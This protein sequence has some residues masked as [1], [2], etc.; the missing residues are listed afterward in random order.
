MFCF[1]ELI[2]VIDRLGIFFPRKDM[3]K[4]VEKCFDD[5]SSFRKKITNRFIETIQTIIQITQAVLYKIIVCDNQS[6]EISKR[7]LKIIPLTFFRWFTAS[8]YFNKKAKKFCGTNFCARSN[9]KHFCETN[10]CD[11]GQNLKNHFRKN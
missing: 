8:I 5:S 6:L 3:K 4:N 1:A 9:L 2:F 10:F 7:Y 11:F